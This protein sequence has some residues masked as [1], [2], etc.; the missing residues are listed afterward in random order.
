MTSEDKIT[1]AAGMIFLKYG[2]HATTLAAIADLA[3]V[4]KAAIH[5]YFRSKDKL[6]SVVL[7]NLFSVNLNLKNPNLRS[8]YFLTF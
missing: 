8:L 1:L 7:K 5:Y 4:S 6:Y 3:H 2:Y